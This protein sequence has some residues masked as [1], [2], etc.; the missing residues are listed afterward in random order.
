MVYV[1]WLINFMN[2]STDLQNNLM[3]HVPF[4]DNVLLV[5]SPTV[6]VCTPKSNFLI[7]VAWKV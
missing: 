5:H 2:W 1:Y 3:W 4:L 7:N 6:K